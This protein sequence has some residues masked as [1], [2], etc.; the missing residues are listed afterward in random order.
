MNDR[1]NKAHLTAILKKENRLMQWQNGTACLV[2]P[3]SLFFY[4]ENDIFTEFEF[5][6][7]GVDKPECCILEG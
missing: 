1:L 2:K 4:S 5:S 3:S 7:D 6:L